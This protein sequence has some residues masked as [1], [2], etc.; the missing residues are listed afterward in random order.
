MQPGHIDAENERKWSTSMRIN[1]PDRGLS[2][3]QCGCSPCSRNTGGNTSRWPVCSSSRKRSRV[4]VQHT[5][6]SSRSYFSVDIVHSCSSSRIALS[7]FY[8]LAVAILVG[9]SRSST[10]D[11][12]SVKKGNTTLGRN[13]NVVAIS[14]S[15]FLGEPLKEKTEG[16]DKGKARW[17]RVKS[18]RAAHPAMYV[19]GDGLVYCPIAKVRVVLRYSTT[20]VRD[21]GHRYRFCR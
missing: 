20:S 16:T 6:E 19:P 7:I 13:S 2:R 12:E 21:L 8:L 11:R 9:S 3:P 14:S 4:G 5:S 15:S 1:S 17:M 18:A 10:K